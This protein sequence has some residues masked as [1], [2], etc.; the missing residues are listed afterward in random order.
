[1]STVLSKRRSF[2]NETRRQKALEMVAGAS[3]LLYAEGA[4][5][6][7]VFGS[8]L[9]PGAFDER[10]DVDIAVKGI[11]DD[12]RL[13]LERKLEDVFADMPFDIVFLED[14]LR[15][16]DIDADMKLIMPRASCKGT[17]PGTRR[18]RT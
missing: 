6:V 16:A 15:I 11:A 2:L 10:S 13:S 12:K 4:E 9:K 8:V 18:C 3:A 1:M 14:A 7:Y 5:D 17:N